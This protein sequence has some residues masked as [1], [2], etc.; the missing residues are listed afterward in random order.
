MQSIWCYIVLFI[1]KVCSKLLLGM[2]CF[3]FIKGTLCVKYTNSRTDHLNTF[4][5]IEIVIQVHYSTHYQNFFVIL[6]IFEYFLQS[7]EGMV[8]QLIADGWEMFW[9]L[10]IFFIVSTNDWFSTCILVIYCF[11]PLHSNLKLSSWK[12]N[13]SFA[14]LL[15][16]ISFFLVL[17]TR[18]SILYLWKLQKYML[19]IAV[20]VGHSKKWHILWFPTF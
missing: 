7:I 10:C 17:Y 1:G 16:L 14:V 3:I 5:L 20:T 4:Y 18:T 19:L 9:N 11:P 2:K 8:L 6:L 13:S 15:I 12:H